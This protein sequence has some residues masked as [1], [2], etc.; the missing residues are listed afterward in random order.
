MAQDDAIT[1][2]ARQI[3]AASRAERLIASGDEIDAL[4]RNGAS[5]LHK[6]CAEFVASVN[7]RLT[8]AMLELSPAEYAPEMFRAPG[9]NLIQIGAQGRE[10][11]IA[12]EAPRELISTEKFAIPYILEG[13]VRT[14]NQKMLE[15]FEIR[16]RLLY[17]CLQGD[18]A[19]WRYFDWRT[20]NTG[21]FGRDLLVSLLEPLFG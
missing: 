19:T 5:V 4:R 21:E 3:D 20:R 13:E 10:I 14:Y 11:Q 8:D 1:R 18:T 2:L 6:L 9:A 16:S 7:S 15:R 12:F 17:F